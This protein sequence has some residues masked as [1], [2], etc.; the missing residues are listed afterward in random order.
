MLSEVSY[1]LPVRA[2][3]PALAEALH[4][5]GTAVLVAPPG[6]G[7]HSKI[8]TA[9]STLMTGREGPGNISRPPEVQS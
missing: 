2:A 3:L 6:T 5:A 7:K 1:D 9:A 4:A 8:S